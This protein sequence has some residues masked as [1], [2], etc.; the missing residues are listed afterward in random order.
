L[1]KHSD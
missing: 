1:L